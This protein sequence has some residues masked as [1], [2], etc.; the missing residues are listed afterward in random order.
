[1]N[2]LPF[3]G[4]RLR[5]IR[6]NPSGSGVL[7]ELPYRL[8]PTNNRVFSTHGLT[9]ST[10]VFKFDDDDDATSRGSDGIFT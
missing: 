8:G 3:R 10:T 5:E 6:E 2:L 1:M 4:P 9:F 7:L